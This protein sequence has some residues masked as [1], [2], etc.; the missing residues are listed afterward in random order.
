V[1][2]AVAFVALATID[3][4]GVW[5]VAFRQKPSVSVA[6]ADIRRSSSATS[7]K[8]STQP[9][10]TK[11]VPDRFNERSYWAQTPYRFPSGTP[12]TRDLVRLRSR[13]RLGPGGRPDH[14]V[15]AASDTRT[16]RRVPLHT[17]SMETL[18]VCAM[19]VVGG[20]VQLL[21]SA[22]RERVD[23]G[24]A[25]EELDLEE[26]I[27]DRTPLADQLVHARFD[28]LSGS[29]RVDVAPRG[30]TRRR[31][32]DRHG[33]RRGPIG[34]RPITRCTSRAS[35]RNATRPFASL[36]TVASAIAVQSPESAQW[37]RRTCS[38]AS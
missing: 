29:I 36:R 30:G 24:A 21:R 22:E 31:A 19:T 4:A 33:E 38:G 8:G 3:R 6:A 16:D 11:G 20:R 9:G 28:Q 14:H 1:K 7:P 18:Y 10:F 32:I 2:R 12:P 34:R 37:L 15:R 35:N 5:W 26:T 13:G 27:G 23:R 17:A 25:V